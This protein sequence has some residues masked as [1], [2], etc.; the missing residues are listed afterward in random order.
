LRRSARLAKRPKPKGTDIRRALVS[1]GTNSTRLLVVDG[2]TTLTAESQGTRLGSG[3]AE[4]GHLDPAAKERTLTTIA[5]YAASVRAADATIDCIATSAMRRAAD[6]AAF[7]ADVEA[8]LGV[9]PRVLSGDEE[10]AYSFLG[11]TR[12]VDGA[13]PVGVLDA[14]GGSTELAVDVPDRAR[15]SGTVERTRSLEFGAVRLSERHP[16]LMGGAALDPPARAAVVARARADAAAVLAPLRDV[17]PVPR[18][19]AVGGTVFTAAA[20]IAQ[21]PLRDGVEISAPARAGLID[22]LLARDL[23]ERRA[24]PF[25]RPQRAD[26]L[27]A[28]IIV[29]DEACRSLGVDPVRVSVDDLLAG[30]LFS[31]A[32][33][34]ARA[35]NGRGQG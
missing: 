3:L 6:G 15:R 34:G 31:A 28:G 30:Y 7:A 33:R 27:P 1:I 10:A 2:E 32:Y 14:G 24:M 22:A 5:G 9:A 8:L 19:I 25:I 23:E 16:E 17:G 4:R 12:H 13:D 20:M 11:A 21:A 35:K 26:I 18:L 29:V